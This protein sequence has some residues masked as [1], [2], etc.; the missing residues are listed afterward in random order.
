MLGPLPALHRFVLVLA[1]LVV[2]IGLG[3]WFG[4]V[5]ETH[6]N[7]RVGLL[8]GAGAGVAAAFVLVHD[9]HRRESRRL[10]AR[11]RPH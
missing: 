5:P 10:R 6:V 1:A 7:L 4:A 3:L 11:R 9:F 2:C 8:A